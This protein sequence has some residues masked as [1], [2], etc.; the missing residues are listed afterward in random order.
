MAASNPEFSDYPKSTPPGYEEPP[1]QHGCFFYGCIIASI[2]SVL[3]VIAVGAFL[4]LGYRMLG[5]AIEEYTSTT[6]RELPKV[7][8]PA[9]QRRNA[10]DRWA[11]FRK[12][13]EETKP[14]EPLVLNSDEINALID[15][16]EDLKDLKGMVYVS[17]D[18]DKLKGQ[19]SIPLEKFVNVG[20][21]R[22]RFLNGEAEI[23]ATVANDVLVMTLESIE[24]NGKTMPAEAMA[25]LRGQNLAEN[26]YKDPKKAALL[27]NLQS[28]EIKDGKLTIKAKDLTKKPESDKAEPSPGGETKDGKAIGHPPEGTPAPKTEVPPATKKLPDDVLAPSQPSAPAPAEAAKKPPD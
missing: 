2:L 26:A 6:P 22:G 21:T 5:R 4:F 14:S 16:Q 28:V 17:I 3:L 8:M 1:R 25:Q 13:L 15:E 9:E 19:I 12:A 7:E 20:L 11:A 24:V 10:Q 27:N 23:K 18:Q